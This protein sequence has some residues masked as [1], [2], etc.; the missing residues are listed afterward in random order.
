MTRGIKHFVDQFITELQGKYLPFKWNGENRTIQVAVRPIQL[1][2]I[3]F[4]ESSKDVVLN[5]I[6]GDP[7]NSGKKGEP[8]YKHQKKWVTAIRKILKAEKL[9]EFKTDQVMPINRQHMEL[10][11]IGVKKDRYEGENEML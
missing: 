10:I 9:P 1:W 4:P 5:T 2:E 7:N 3:V 11:G 6:L 8:Q